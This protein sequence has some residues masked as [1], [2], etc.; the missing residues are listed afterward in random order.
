[1]LPVI[2]QL[3]GGKSHHKQQSDGPEMNLLQG[4][5]VTLTLKVTTVFLCVTVQLYQTISKFHHKQQSYGLEKNLIQGRPVILTL[6]VATG[7]LCGTC[8]LVMLDQL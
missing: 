2:S 3:E 5:P 7:I 4:R 6:K 8:H 1:M